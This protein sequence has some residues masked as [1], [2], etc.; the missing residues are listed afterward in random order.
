MPIKNYTDGPTFVAFMDISGFKNYMKEGRGLEKLETFFN[1]SFEILKGYKNEINSIFISD[2]GILFV[3]EPQDELMRLK[4]LLKA[5]KEI[6]KRMLDEDIILTTSISYG[7]FR[8]VKRIEFEGMIKNK[9]YGNA[10]VRAVID[11]TEGTPK[12]KPGQ[13]RILKEKLPIDLQIN[14]DDEVFDLIKTRKY[15]TNNHYFYW[16]L[17]DSNEIDDFEEKYKNAHKFR[18]KIG[19]HLISDVLNDYKKYT[20]NE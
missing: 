20:L 5:I 17:I 16:N 2:C 14:R 6:N 13:C 19:Y 18:K 1:G 15:D 10:Y 3:R 12:I 11:N 8:Y 4:I 9:V 7:A